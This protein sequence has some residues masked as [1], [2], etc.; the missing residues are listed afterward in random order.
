MNLTPDEQRI[1]AA[2][3]QIETPMYDITAAVHEQRARRSRRIPLRSP[4]RILASVLAAILLTMTAAAAV[5]QLSGGW[6]AIFGQGVAVPE[7][8]TVPLQ[9]S[10]TV[11]GCTVTLEDAIVSSSSIAAIFSVQMADG[12][13]LKDR[14][15]FGDI[16]LSIDGSALQTP[17]SIQTVYD[18]E[19]SEIQYSYQEY[20]YNGQ[21]QDNPS[22]INLTFVVGPI[23]RIEN[24][25]P[26]TAQIDLSALYQA[27][28]L[29]LTE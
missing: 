27:Q 4:Q 19:H 15:E 20:E 1:R 13:A 16:Q 11:D 22:E 17:H 23:S 18:Q 3:E 21:T 10:Q 6:H 7:E 9:S 5:M 28:P 12:T 8:I 24:P 26:L 2:L 29:T 14:V 25:A